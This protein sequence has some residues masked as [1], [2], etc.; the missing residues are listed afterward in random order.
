MIS[1]LTHWTT[2]AVFTNDDKGK[3]EKDSGLPQ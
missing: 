2:S 3:N 1:S